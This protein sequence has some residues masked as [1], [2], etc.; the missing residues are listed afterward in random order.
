MIALVRAVIRDSIWLTSMFHVTGSESTT[1]DTPPLRTIWVMQEM[2]VKLGRITSSPACRSSAS[3]AASIAALPLHTAMACL[4]PTRSANSRSNL[5][6]KGPSEDI[7]PVSMHSRRYF[8]SLP[9]SRGSLTGIFWCWLI[10]STGPLTTDF[11][12]EVTVD[13]VPEF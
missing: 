5:L 8:L 2:I 10:D 7:Q 1:T 11:E 6:M 3:I 4:R 9:S 13:V 12:D